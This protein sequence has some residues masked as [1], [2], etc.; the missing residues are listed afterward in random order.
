MEHVHANEKLSEKCKK[1][2]EFS[3]K[4][5]KSQECKYYQK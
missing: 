3:L 4:Y 2:I 5:L 1:D